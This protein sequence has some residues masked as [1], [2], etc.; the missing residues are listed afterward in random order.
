MALIEDE[1]EIVK[2]L[3]REE[4]LRKPNNKMQKTSQNFVSSIIEHIVIPNVTKNVI[5]ENAEEKKDEEDEI[6]I[7]T[8]LFLLDE[9]DKAIIQLIKIN[10]WI[11]PSFI[12]RVIGCSHTAIKYRIYALYKEGLLPNYNGLKEAKQRRRF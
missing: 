10:C 2:I 12:A 8:S 7:E 9:I 1:P 6:E 5:N 4:L 11:T 3:R